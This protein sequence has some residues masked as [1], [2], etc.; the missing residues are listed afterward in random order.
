MH[1]ITRLTLGV[2]ALAATQLPSIAGAQGTKI[3]VGY[4]TAADYL[5]AFMAKEIGCFEKNGLDVTLTRMQIVGNIPPALMAGSLQVGISTPPVHLQ[6]IDGGL[7]LV[8][9]AGA[10]RMVKGNP[11]ISLVL[12]QGV[13]IKSAADLKGKK[14]GVPGINSVADVML[15]K[16]LKNSGVNPSDVTFIETPFPQM[17]DLLK[18]GTVDGVTAVEPIRS[19]IEGSGVGK[20]APEEY[21]TAVHPDTLLAFFTSTGAWAKANADAIKKFRAC[22]GDGIAAIKTN[23]DAAKDAEKKYLGFNTPSLPTLT[24]DVKPDDFKFFVD[25]SKEFGLIRKDVDLKALVAP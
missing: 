8:A 17:A 7:D 16:W 20:R 4:A 19:R 13:D 15:R 3:N 1:R 12:R 6:A 5:P 22:L 24:V 14:I 11:T 25:L 10:T 18:A 9:I 23:P 2:L 21:Y